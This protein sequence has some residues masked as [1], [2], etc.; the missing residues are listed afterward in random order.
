MRDHFEEIVNR[1]NSAIAYR[2]F[3]PDFLDHGE[4]YSETNGRQRA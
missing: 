2:N 1:K 3:T 4:P